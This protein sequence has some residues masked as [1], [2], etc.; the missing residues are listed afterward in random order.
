MRFLRFSAALL[1]AGCGGDAGTTDA[2][3]ATRDAP[4]CPPG[5]HLCGINCT[6]DLPNDTRNGCRLGC[7][8]ACPIPTGGEAR[9]LSDGTCD[10]TCNPPYSRSGDGCRCNPVSCSSMGV[11]CGEIDDG[12]GGRTN[13]GDCGTGRECSD[14]QC[15]CALDDAEPNDDEI[16]AFRIGTFA[17]DP[18]SRMTFDTYG[19][20]S[21]TDVDFYRA[22]IVDAAMSNPTIRVTLSNVPTGH[23]YDLTAWFRCDAG[24]DASRCDS[25]TMDTELGVG[26]AAS[27]MD[28][29]ARVQLQTFCDTTSE[30]GELTIRVRS[31][32]W[33][34]A[35]VAYEI[36]LEVS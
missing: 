27:S 4:S 10:V 30:S 1:L 8:V 34:N 32:A 16:R 11:M 23:A 2:G 19:L 36:L 25:G 28:A 33:T 31:T 9:C 17:D 29:M 14:G 12:C 13:C 24:G 22:R 18:D 5:Q 3:P 35:C 6:D 20:H 21:A 26:C 7:G 15:S